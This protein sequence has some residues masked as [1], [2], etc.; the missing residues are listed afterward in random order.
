MFALVIGG[1]IAG[2]IGAILAL[3][4]TA[5]ARDV[6]AYLFARVSAPR[7]APS[8]GAG[9]PAGSIDGEPL[10]AAG[11]IFAPGP[12]APLAGASGSRQPPAAG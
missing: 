2:L 7:A 1:A 11:P 10:A 5:A 3:P 4:I 9:P 12:A 6:F 8:T